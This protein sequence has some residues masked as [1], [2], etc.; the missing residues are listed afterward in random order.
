MS[1]SKVALAENEKQSSHKPLIIYRSSNYKLSHP[2]QRKFV[3]DVT[4]RF[5]PLYDEWMSETH[6]PNMSSILAHYIEAKYVG[7]K[8]ADIGCG[9]GVLSSLFLTRLYS[10]YVSAVLKGDL[11][12]PR[13][14]VILFCVDLSESMLGLAKKNIVGALHKIV[15]ISDQFSSPFSLQRPSKEQKP[16]LGLIESQDISKQVHLVVKKEG[17]QKELINVH[18]VRGHATTLLYLN[19]AKD[20][21]TVLVS[22][23]FHWFRGL[24]EKKEVARLLYEVLRPGGNFISIEEYPL[25]VRCDLHPTPEMLALAALIKKATTVLPMP[26]LYELF[27]E[28]G[29]RLIPEANRL[30]PIDEYHYMFGRVFEKPKN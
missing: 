16:M 21:D 24:S 8:V 3:C 12:L 9:T 26:E 27:E 1:I 28:V 4:E 29:F 18:F 2:P 15:R 10:N 17:A 5:S 25:T 22:Y 6:Y 19:E 23:V 13:S 11:P 20:L 14:P 30:L 7:R